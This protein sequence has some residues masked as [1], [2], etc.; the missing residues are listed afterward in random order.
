MLVFRR[1]V[2]AVVSLAG[3]TNLA[4]AF[5]EA[6]AGMVRDLVGAS[7]AD[8]ADAYRQASPLR[9]IGPG[10]APILMV[11]GDKDEQV[12]YAQVVAMRDACL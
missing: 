12:P 5:P 8:A 10:M 11:H 6:S 7:P 9:R 3:P 2:R 1:P 4:A